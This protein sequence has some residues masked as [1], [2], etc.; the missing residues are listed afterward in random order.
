MDA[1]VNSYLDAQAAQSIAAPTITQ[2]IGRQHEVRVMLMMGVN[3]ATLPVF[4]VGQL[5][6]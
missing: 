2:S 6:P 5:F 1:R 3:A 4:T